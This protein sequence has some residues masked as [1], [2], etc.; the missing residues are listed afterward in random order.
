[1]LAARGSIVIVYGLTIMLLI[2]AAFEAF[3]SSARWMPP[4]VKYTVGA[5]CWL[6]VLAYLTF[7]GRRASGCAGREVASACA[8]RSAAPGRQSLPQLRTLRLC[9]LSRDG[10]TRDGA[11]RCDVRVRQM[12]AA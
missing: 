3:W 9:V 7:Q 2:A 8:A 4:T 6:A 1:V 5:A 11:L 10:R 12:V